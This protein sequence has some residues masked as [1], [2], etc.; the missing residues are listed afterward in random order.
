MLQSL[1]SRVVPI[2]SVIAIL[3]YLTLEV[4]RLC[5]QARYR[6]DMVKRYCTTRTNEQSGEMICFFFRSKTGVILKSTH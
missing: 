2:N 4:A 6:F 5:D 3:L 1:F